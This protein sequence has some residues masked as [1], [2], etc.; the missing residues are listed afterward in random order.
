[1]DPITT[2]QQSGLAGLLIL[3]VSA[4]VVWQARKITALEKANKDLIDASL[5][6]LAKA[7]DRDA[8]R[9]RTL[10]EAE[11]RRREAVS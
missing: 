7:Q 5:G 6:M 2:W 8:E 10:E 4:I 3:V 11:R 9:L 1:M